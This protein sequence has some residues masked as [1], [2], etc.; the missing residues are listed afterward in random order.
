MEI[1]ITMK[2]NRWVSGWPRY[3]FKHEMI[4]D[5]VEVEME[6]S[7][8]LSSD[9]GKNYFHLE[10]FEHKSHLI[11]HILKF[12]S[13]YFRRFCE[14][15][16][17][18]WNHNGKLAVFKLSTTLCDLHTNIMFIQYIPDSYC[19]RMRSCCYLASTAPANSLCLQ[20]FQKF[21]GNQFKCCCYWMC[22]FCYSDI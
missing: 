7:M 4:N 18:H 6:S 10:K 21:K 9:R 11:L 19:A 14:I 16:K 12:G 2:I 1:L 8:T 20:K 3:N 13:I 5:P 22:E 15:E 17:D